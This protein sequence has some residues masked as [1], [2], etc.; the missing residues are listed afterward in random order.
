MKP[1][2]YILCG[3]PGCGKSTWAKRFWYD[4]IDT[5][6]VSRDDIRFSLLEDDDDY[7]S[8]EEEVFVKFVAAIRF[9]LNNN[10]N[11][12][13]DATH[14]NK[15]SRK[16]LIHAIDYLGEIDYQIIFV[17]FNTPYEICCGRNASREGRA[18]V[19]DDIMK[20]MRNS[21]QPPAII[22]DNRCV[23]LMLMKGM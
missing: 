2:L 8:H 15:K 12:I 16:K 19:P 3:C 10:Q 17:Y 5:V 14:L 18:R 1:T 7:F 6:Y 23:G 21:F 22:E 9:A 13:A 11:C 20:S 4:Q